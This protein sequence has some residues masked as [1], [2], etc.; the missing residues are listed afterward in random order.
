M[1]FRLLSCGGDRRAVNG[2]GEGVNFGKRRFSA[3]E[4]NFTFVAVEPRF[5]VS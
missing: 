2:K 5:N 1:T 3:N 4:K